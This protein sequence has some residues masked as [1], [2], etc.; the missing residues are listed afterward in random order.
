MDPFTISTGIRGFLSL[1][2]E[3]VDILTEYTNTVKPAAIPSDARK[4]LTEVASLTQV[5]KQLTDFLK[6]PEHDI[7]FRE[8]SV[9]CSIVEICDVRIK[10]LHSKLDKFQSIGKTQ[11]QWSWPFTKQECLDIAQTLQHCAET[12][13][14]SL[15]IS[16]GYSKF[17]NPVGL[18]PE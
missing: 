8:T 6:K 5:L 13:Q 14:L 12:I 18:F 10:N 9:L 2:I 11:G 16:N 3:L 7:D 17:I 1:A 15:T 4:L